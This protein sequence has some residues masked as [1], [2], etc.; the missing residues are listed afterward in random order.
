M[1]RS[2]L[3]AF[4]RLTTGVLAGLLLR[5]ASVTTAQSLPPANGRPQ[6]QPELSLLAPTNLMAWCIV[7]FD[8]KKR[9]PEARA[10]MLDRLG[11]RHFAYDWR[12]EHIPSFDEE[13][14]TMRRHGISIDAWWFPADLG[15][16][17]RAI[18]DALQR[19]DIHPQLWI[20]MGDPAPQ[21]SGADKVR[22]ASATLR[23]IA[24]EAAKRGCAVGLYNHGG[25]FGEP[26][27]QLAI[28]KEL[29]MTNVGIVYNFHHGHDHIERFAELFP[30]MQ[31][32]LLAV[33]LNGMVKG[34]DRSGKKI[35]TLGEGDQEWRM[36]QVILASNWH[37]LIGILDHRDETDS[38]ET[39]RANL[40]GLN[41]LREALRPSSPPA[42]PADGKPP[43]NS[44]SRASLSEPAPIEDSAVRAQ[45]PE[46]VVEPP[47]RDSELT[48]ANGFPQATIFRKWERS[49]G[50]ASGARFSS[51]NQVDRSNV[52]NLELAWTYHSG[53]GNGNI[54]CNPVIVDGVLFT[55]TPG[56]CI[57]AVDGAT[58]TE[59]WRFKLTDLG[60]SA[61]LADAP[62][63]RG[64]VYWAG[65]GEEP[66]RLFFAVNRWVYAIDVKTGRP[67]DSF[68]IH[69]RVPLETAGTVAGAIFQNVLVV[70]GFERDVF[71]F[72]VRSGR[73]LWRFHTIPRPGEFGA[74]T[75]DRPEQ[76]A[77]C[78]GGMAMDTERGIAYVATGSPKPD[79][80]GMGHRG[81]NLFSDCLIALDA[82]TGQRLWHF[83]EVRHDI[84]DWDIPSPPVLV[85]VNV[86]GRRVDAVAAVTKLG[87]TLLLDRVSG[88]PLFPFRLKRAPTTK[89]PGE[90]TW[91]YQPSPELP[92]P[93]V[94]QEFR[95]DD[96]TQRT[97]E[98]T[99]AVMKVVSRAN[100]GWFTAF[101]EAKP[102][103][104][105]NEH[106]GAEWT[107]AAY[108]PGS[109]RLFV[110]VNE[111]PWYITV[112]RDD[113]VAR[114]NH[115]SP[116]AGE[117]LFQINC[118]QCHGPD[119]RGLTQAPPLIGLRH[120]K[121]EAEVLAQ[122]ENGKGAMPSH[123]NLTLPEKKALVDYLLLRDGAIVPRP[124]GAPV[125][126]TFGGWQKLLDDEGYPGCTPP[127]GSLVCLDLNTGRIVWK[128]P[129]GEHEELTR[130]GVAKTGTENFG[131]ATVT[132]GNLVFASGTRDNRIR[133]FDAETG[134]ELWSY[135]L[136]RHGTAPISVYEAR[137]RQY[138]VVPATGGGKLGGPMGDALVAFALP[139]DK[140][141]RTTAL[142]RNHELP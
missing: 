6:S 131:G 45:M 52:K 135:G 58:G 13:I 83:Q 21:G 104:L 60:P 86:R 113:E 20:T 88:K 105:F 47:A 27:N 138:V 77:N 96:V 29:Q 31:S 38:E 69:G 126:W 23:P 134:A 87:N 84:W 15:K 98:A 56:G 51:L 17:S 2:Y 129:L 141:E 26:E 40:Q 42:S 136:P 62:A 82:R 112:F 108:H 28:L 22:A 66:A 4:R 116:T 70:P 64:M 11:F 24:E 50:D 140:N 91:P 120:R 10:Q 19:H 137:G 16:T 100:F 48:L 81:Q 93:I 76:G 18:L 1:S 119:R 43:A 59:V 44:P 73:L 65:D 78:W 32:R 80:L 72:D 114:D 53:D 33:N 102:T 118:A 139:L 79:F 109:G 75:W 5:F 55:P 133:A 34:G 8:A 12:D 101:E 67:I 71:G 123:P 115:G 49:H 97:E 127:W 7:P 37:G 14:E 36:L 128:V 99:D 35:L 57:A 132:A 89:I 63:R 92:E 121:T 30:K 90:H 142:N 110:S 106:G 46:T 117:Q 54:Q 39:L 122:M 103:V 25:W 41:R 124:Q 107:G 95:L 125:R 74:E 94:R 130:R 9:G 68:G 61:G 111:I 3:A 85:T